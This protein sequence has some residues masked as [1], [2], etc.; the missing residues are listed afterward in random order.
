MHR[1]RDDGEGVVT[2]FDLLQYGD[3]NDAHYRIEIKVFDEDEIREYFAANR[4][5]GV[6]LYGRPQGRAPQSSIIGPEHIHGL[7]LQEE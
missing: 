1:F 3:G 5:V 2:R 6:R 7:G 4:L